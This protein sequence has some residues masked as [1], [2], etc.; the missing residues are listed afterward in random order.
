MGT[1]DL[2]KLQ[3]STSHK[4]D[5]LLSMPA[6]MCVDAPTIPR[7]T[8]QYVS[9]DD[10]YLI[11]GK[12]SFERQFAQLY[13]SRLM[14]LRPVVEQQ[15]RQQW[16]G[17]KVVK[18][19]GVGEDQEVAVIGTLYKDMK[20]KPSILDEYSK[21]PG[22]KQTLGG[23]TFCSDDDSLVLEDE[24]ARMTLR[25]ECNE[26]LPDTVV[27]GPVIAVKGKAEP[28]GDF[29]VTGV[30]WPGLAE[31][32]Q[33]PVQEQDSY[34]AFVSG[35]QLANSK[36]DIMQIQLL[37]DFLTGNLGA[38]PQQELAAKVVQLVVAGGSLG[39]LEV[40][41]AANPYSR[42]QTTD[43]E[44]VRDMDMYMTELAAALPVDIMPGPDDPANVSL[45]QQPLHQC[46]FPGAAPYSSF[47]RVTNPHMVDLSG[48]RILGTSGQNVDD[49]AKYTRGV[50][51]L[52]LLAS[53]LQ[54]RHLCPTAPDT[55]TCYPFADDDPFVMTSCPHIMFAG[56]QP[57][58]DTKQLE[59]EII[60]R[61]M[62]LPSR[63]V[64]PAVRV[65]AEVYG[66]SAA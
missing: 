15:V 28:G 26:L 4:H 12:R 17:V 51:R 66:S 22:F 37:V 45:P 65:T 21:Y 61:T 23:T 19:L 50:S 3:P 53:C 59:G 60:V 34:V 11:R 57:E 13:F 58:F 48:V 43:M 64:M 39:Q 18:I 62:I 49:M 63:Q 30:S 16:P 33:R 24:G 10:R 29:V 52:D 6:D 31:Q 1:L 36:A 14:L 56:N 54:W 25:S 9:Q 42:Q 47:R 40:M 7:A 41:A 5:E 38:A 46:L 44:P 27:T 2:E 55:L 8:C 35:L 20:L 32:P